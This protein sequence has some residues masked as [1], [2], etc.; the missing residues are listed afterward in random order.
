MKRPYDIKRGTE[1]PRSDPYAFTE[2]EMKGVTLHCGF[3]LWIADKNGK[4]RFDCEALDQAVQEFK[5]LTGF[6]PEQLEKF[7]HKRTSRCPK[8]GSK[9][10]D[11][12]Y[13]Y[14]GET[15]TVCTKCDTIVDSHLNMSAIE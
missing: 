13:G 8:C 4:R 5:K 9:E 7:E 3:D 11:T 14:P 12:T 1:G 15:F 6:T 10:L 2:Y